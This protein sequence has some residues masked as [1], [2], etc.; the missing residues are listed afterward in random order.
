MKIRL[1]CELIAEVDVAGGFLPTGGDRAGNVAIST[2]PAT[3]VKCQGRASE[4]P[5]RIA[6]DEVEGDESD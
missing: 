2:M 1:D 6:L 4:A 3:C 5:D